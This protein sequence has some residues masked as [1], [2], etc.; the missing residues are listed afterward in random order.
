MKFHCEWTIQAH[1]V[2][3]VLVRSCWIWSSLASM[4]HSHQE[5][6]CDSSTYAMPTSFRS[7]TWITRS[8]FSC[9]CSTYRVLSKHSADCMRSLSLSVK[10]LIHNEVLLCPFSLCFKA[11]ANIF[12]HSVKIKMWTFQIMTS[13]WKSAVHTIAI[14]THKEKV[15]ENWNQTTLMC[16]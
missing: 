12:S 5:T 13:T 2:A 11:M 9:E 10:W 8:H 6:T 7:C 3:A 15:F 1:T 4:L 14:A 16:I